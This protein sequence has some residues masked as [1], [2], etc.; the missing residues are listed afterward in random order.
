VNLIV[1]IPLEVRLAALF[2]LGACAGG[3]INLGT[4]RLAW[5]PRSISPW[6][7]PDAKAPPRRLWDR[8][9]VIGWLGLRR[10]AG[11]HG[12]GF[13]IRPLLLEL[14]TGVGFAALYWW[15]IGQR[16]LLMSAVPQRPAPGLLAVLHTQYAAH[17]ALMSLLL[18][19]SMIDL[20]EKTIPDAI[21]APGTILG[22]LL[23]AACPWSL[24]GGAV[25]PPNNL[26]PPGFWNGL[27]P[28]NWPL[29]QLTSPLPLRLWPPWL[30]GLWG[31]GIGLGCCWLW[32]VGLMPRSWYPRH[33]SRRAIQ[34]CLARLARE[35]ATYRILLMGLIASA[36]IAAVWLLGGRGWV[37]LLSGLVGMAAGGGLVWL[38][39]V[40]GT[41]AL[42]REAMGFGDVTL[43]AMIGAFLGWQTCLIVFFIAPFAGL[44]VGVLQVILIRDSRI[45]YGPFLCLGTVVTIVFWAT[46]W[47]RTW[48]I[49]A[50]GWL[51]PLF[52]LFCLGLMALMLGLWRSIREGFRSAAHGRRSAGP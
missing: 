20:D 5:H 14:L 38:V 2:V 13:W 1:A 35:P 31:L 24:P 21:T 23:A 11:L 19:A 8:L 9:P 22:L 33:G 39:R 45:P 41:A 47:D 32:C 34:L 29:L 7:R 3:L 12:A 48:N 49:F 30:S 28:E 43:M 40:I 18:V 36:A 50:L 27:S 46:I 15:E 25:P 4:Y 42:K 37:G 10:E 26:F 51:V 52:V 16:G 17:L 44:V 6:S